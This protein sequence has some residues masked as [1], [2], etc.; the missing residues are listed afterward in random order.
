M[1]NICYELY[2]KLKVDEILVEKKGKYITYINVLKKLFG[3]GDDLL[4]SDKLRSNTRSYKSNHKN[5]DD[6]KDEWEKYNLSQFSEYFR[7]EGKL[8]DFKN[9]VYKKF[10]NKYGFNETE[11]RNKYEKIWSF[12][13]QLAQEESENKLFSEDKYSIFLED[14][15]QKNDAIKSSSS[16]VS[17]KKCGRI[18]QILVGNTV[19]GEY[20]DFEEML[21]QAILLISCTFLEPPNYLSKMFSFFGLVFGASESEFLGSKLRYHISAKMAYEK[22]KEFFV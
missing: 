10:E 18:F 3:I 16:K 5:S 4:D 22:R 21:L 2:Q 14:I 6:D 1:K 20:D 7:N 13:D 15:G 11:L 8:Q 9:L 17:V 19:Y 12:Y